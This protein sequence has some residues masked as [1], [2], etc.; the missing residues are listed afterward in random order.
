MA[1]K[2]KE[3]T[4]QVPIAKA[5]RDSTINPEGAIELAGS[6]DALTADT[7]GQIGKIGQEFFF[8]VLLLSILFL[9]QK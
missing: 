3:Y 6:T 4:P 2:L 8:F 9:V 5:Q 7:F 1:I